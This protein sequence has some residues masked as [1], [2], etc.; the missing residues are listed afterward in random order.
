LPPIRACS[1]IIP[2]NSAVKLRTAG[3][4]TRRLDNPPPLS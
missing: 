2:E 4:T 1:S 3:L